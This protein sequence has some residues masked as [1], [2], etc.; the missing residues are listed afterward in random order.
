MLLRWFDLVSIDNKI[1]V[2]F[3][4]V[5]KIGQVLIYDNKIIYRPRVRDFLIYIIIIL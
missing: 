1:R 5:P 2:V 4:D 3:D